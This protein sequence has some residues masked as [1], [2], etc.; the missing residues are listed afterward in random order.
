MRWYQH[1]WR[2]Q[3]LLMK[4]KKKEKKTGSPISNC[5]SVFTQVRLLHRQVAE[6][7]FH[8]LL[9]PFILIIILT[10]NL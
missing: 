7:V 9:C 5:A 10:F 4:T 3:S 8:F 6:Y 1:D 2:W